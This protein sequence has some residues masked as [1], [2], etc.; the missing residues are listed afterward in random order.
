MF[1]YLGIFGTQG[2]VVRSSDILNGI[3]TAVHHAAAAFIISMQ[4]AGVIH[5]SRYV[6]GPI[7]ILVMQ[8]WVALLAYSSHALYSAVELVLEY[9]FQWSVLCE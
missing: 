8:H 1:I 9:F 5:P 4:C 3:G 7:M 2:K 6:V